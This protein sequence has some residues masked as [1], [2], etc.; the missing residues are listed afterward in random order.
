M[1]VLLRFLH[2]LDVLRGVDIIPGRWE[3][4]RLD[5]F[6]L[7]IAPRANL[8]PSERESAYGIVA[9][10]THAE[11]ERLYAHARDVL[12]E[13]YRPEAIVVET[14]EG[15]ARPALCYLTSDMEPGPAEADYVERILQPASRLGFPDAYLKKIR[16][17]LP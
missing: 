17:F 14:T 9:T 12:G 7:R 1:D 2:E 13:V 11:L 8:V 6:E 3:A 16:S 5:G 4:A 15:S 10:T